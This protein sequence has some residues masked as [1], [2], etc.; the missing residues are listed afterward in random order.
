M[1]CSIASVTSYLIENEAKIYK[2]A[3]ST[4][5]KFL[6]MKL[7]ISRTIGHIEVGDGSLFAFFTLFHLSLTFF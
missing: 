1:P 4:F 2:M 7:N 5:L 3:T 6:I